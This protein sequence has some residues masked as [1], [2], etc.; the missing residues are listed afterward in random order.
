MLERLNETMDGEAFL[1]K[2]YFRYEEDED[3]PN[4]DLWERRVKPALPL[5]QYETEVGA[6]GKL[7]VSCQTQG[8][9]PGMITFLVVYPKAKEAEGKAYM[10]AL[11]KTRKEAF[12]NLVPLSLPKTDNPAPKPSA[13]D[14]ALGFIPFVRAI[15][16]DI[17]SNSAPNDSERNASVTIAAAQGER[18][19]AQVGIF[20]LKAAEGVKV[21]MSELSGP[22]G[23]KIPASSFTIRRGRNFAKRQGGSNSAILIEFMLKPFETLSLAPGITRTLWVTAHIPE[24]AAAGEYSGTL[25][26]GTA[27]LPVKLSVYPFALD[28]ADDVTISCTGTTGGH[29]LV[30]GDLKERW[31]KAADEALRDQADHGMNA[32]TGGP[33]MNLKGIK[34]GKA[35]I[36]FTDADRWMELAVKHGLTMRGDAYQ[37]FDVNFGFGRS[38]KKD[39]P[40]ANE[41]NSQKLYGMS[42]GDLIKIVF[43]TVEAHAKEKHWP[44]RSY[45]LLDEPRPE[46]GDVESSLELTKIHAQSAPETKFSGYYSGGDG[47]DAIFKF[48]PITIAHHSEASIKLCRDAGKEAWTYTGAGVR[49]DIGRWLFF[50]KQKGLTGFLRNGYEY[51]NSDPYYDFSDT[52]GS[53]AQVYPGKNGLIDT[54][55]WERTAEGVNDYR[56]LKTLQAR[57]DTARKD[58][59]HAAEAD[60]AAKFMQETMKSVNLDQEHSAALKAEQYAQFRAEA[61]KHIAALST[62]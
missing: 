47:R 59:K 32:V 45:Y 51:T 26:V 46:F 35:D 54:V 21:A 57:I 3:T 42:F 30:S 43:G 48:M 13:A 53:W 15:D 14:E 40:Q 12:N 61:A 6:D 62:K 41:Q 52:E 33:G 38:Q 60:A 20:P 25:N 24:N 10:E 7:K 58:G 49:Y 34:D 29:W 17:H 1:N 19:A 23:A 31:W 50:A 44:P 37:G 2:V 5:R 9:W 18:A 27:A 8:G 16:A 56:Y 22:G 55:G 4:M 28:K 11:E 36:D 39:G